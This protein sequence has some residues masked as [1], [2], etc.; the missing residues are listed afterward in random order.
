MIKKKN[1]VLLKFFY[2]IGNFT[3]GEEVYCQ[4]V[5]RNICSDS[6]GIKRNIRYLALS[7]GYDVGTADCSFIYGQKE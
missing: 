3:L 6:Y 2:F 1:L 5:D 7:F 4:D